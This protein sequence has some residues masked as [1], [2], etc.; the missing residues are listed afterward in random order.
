[1]V[2]GPVFWLQDRVEEVVL[3]KRGASWTTIW[4][5]GYTLLCA[6]YSFFRGV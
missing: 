5:A 4:M 6:S 3:W 1:M 2:V